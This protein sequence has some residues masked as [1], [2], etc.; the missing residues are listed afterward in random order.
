MPFYVY[1]LKDETGLLYIGQ[2]N[3][4]QAREKQHQSKSSKAAKFTREGGTFQ[5]VYFE[6]YSTRLESMQ[7]EKKLKN[8]TRAKKD[9]LISGGLKLL[10][11]P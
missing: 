2:T 8:W 4:L 7:R 11:K 5:L 9:A 10:E 6:E 1:F 3:N